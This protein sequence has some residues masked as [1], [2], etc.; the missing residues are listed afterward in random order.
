MAEEWA[1]WLVRAQA[2]EKVEPPW[3]G[4]APTPGWDK[5][6]AFWWWLYPSTGAVP[7]QETEAAA[8]WSKVE[9]L[10]L[11]EAGWDK[12]E[13]HW[14]SLYPAASAIRRFH[15]AQGEQPG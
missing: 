6:E 13:S 11:E 3:E 4:Q 5:V 1:K 12:E 7:R 14:W 8:S 2:W 15:S 9:G 10:W